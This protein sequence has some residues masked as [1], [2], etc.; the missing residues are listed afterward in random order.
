[1]Y[2]TKYLPN[3]VIRQIKKY[4]WLFDH[5]ISLKTKIELEL[6]DKDEQIQPLL[7]EKKLLKIPE[8][9]VLSDLENGVAGHQ[10]FFFNLARELNALEVLEIGLGMANST[11]TFLLALNETGG[12]L[13]SIEV[14]PSADAMIRI[15]KSGLD[16]NWRLI[17]GASQ[18]VRDRFLPG[19]ELD[20]LFIDG[21]HSY[22]QC[23]LDYELYSPLVRK[24]GY[25]IF[26]DS[27]IISGVKKFTAELS[28]RNVETIYF[29][30]SNGIFVMRK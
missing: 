7:A 22:N 17:E 15:K 3:R 13:T 10:L 6:H 16:N 21:Y 19:F 14:A 26:H 25:I 24:G 29:P 4:P 11:L 23:K 1:M 30:Y 9:S 12:R 5:L 20:I 27:T 2:L 8:F 18:D 28:R